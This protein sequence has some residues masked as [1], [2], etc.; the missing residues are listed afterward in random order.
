MDIHAM[1]GDSSTHVLTTHRREGSD[2]PLQLIS[3]EYLAYLKRIEQLFAELLETLA[4]ADL[5]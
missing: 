5:K 4:K 1:Q 3:T 2:D